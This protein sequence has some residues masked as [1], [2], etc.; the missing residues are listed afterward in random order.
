MYK[1]QISRLVLLFTL[2]VVV[3]GTAAAKENREFPAD[4]AAQE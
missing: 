4:I 2:F 3:R 1:I